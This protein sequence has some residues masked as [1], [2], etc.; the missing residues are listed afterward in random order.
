MEIQKGSSQNARLFVYVK[1]KAC[2]IVRVGV[3]TS[4]KNFIIWMCNDISKMSV[5]FLQLS[6]LNE[7]CCESRALQAP[8]SKQALWAVTTKGDIMAHEPSPCLEA[9][10]QYLPCEQ[11]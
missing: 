3:M 2:L 4:H 8:P 5:N 7:S 10:A 9:P 1:P 6:L 11:M